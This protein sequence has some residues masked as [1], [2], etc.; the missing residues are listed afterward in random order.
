M[1]MKKCLSILLAVVMI[2]TMIT[3]LPITANAVDVDT[4]G[5]GEGTVLPVDDATALEAACKEINDGAG[6]TY[7]ISLTNNIEN[8]Q[9]VITNPNAVVTVIGNGNTR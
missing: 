8:G 9:V 5:V 6:G 2:A 4:A 7:T 1:K 3:S